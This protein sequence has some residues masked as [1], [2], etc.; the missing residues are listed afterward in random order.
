MQHRR[1]LMVILCILGLTTGCTTSPYRTPKDPA[2]LGLPVYMYPAADS[3]HPPKAVVFFFGNDVGFWGP[4]R[5]LSAA[6]A[7]QQ[8]A[9][10]GFDFRG[11]LSALP[12]SGCE[13]E[14]AWSERIQGIIARSRHEL[15]GDS[16]P[17]IIAGH[18]LGAEL[19]IWTAAY[20]RPRGA[21]GVLAISPGSRSHLRVSL[22]DV[23]MTSEP[24]GPGSFS[25]ADAVRAVPNAERIAIVRGVSDRYR[26]ADSSL[27]SAGAPRARKFSV[28]FAGHSMR[29]LL[30][31][32]PVVMRAA[33]WLVK[34][35]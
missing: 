5:D 6:L 26:F 24:T 19:A 22:S 31:S 32:L 12:D 3:A 18:S 9:V 7:R 2:L 23:T 14:E 35:H 34:A 21:V 8:F 1:T 28:W 33:D 25:V 10:A 29:S 16:V 20:A 30:A 17:L 11:V 4:H 27:L 15:G 13:R